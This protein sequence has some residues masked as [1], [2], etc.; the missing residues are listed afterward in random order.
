MYPKNAQLMIVAQD[1]YNT[2]ADEKQRAIFEGRD[3]VCVNG[4]DS[5]QRGKGTP[6]AS[7]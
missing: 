1:F 7:L 5:M 3:A 6:E 2:Y 4:G